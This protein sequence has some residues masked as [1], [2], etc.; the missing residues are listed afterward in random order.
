ME[1]SFRP[2]QD[3]LSTLTLRRPRLTLKRL[4]RYSFFC[5]PKLDSLFGQFS[6]LF[7]SLFWQNH[8]PDIVLKDIS[9]S[10]QH[11]TERH[12]FECYSI[13]LVVVGEGYRWFYEGIDVLYKIKLSVDFYMN[14]LLFFLL[15]ICNIHCRNILIFQGAFVNFIFI[16][17]Y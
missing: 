1:I 2:N 5:G 13:F 9:R 3:S 16:L 10:S 11:L 12:L 14:Y 7:N 8:D 17:F 15:I 6:Y 4:L